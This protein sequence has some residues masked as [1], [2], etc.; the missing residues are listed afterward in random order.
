[1]DVQKI[2]G[3]DKQL[4]KWLARDYPLWECFGLIKFKEKI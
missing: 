1:M 2:D 4:A 3:F